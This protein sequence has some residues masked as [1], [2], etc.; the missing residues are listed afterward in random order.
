MSHRTLYLIVG[1]VVA[2]LLVVLF[3]MFDYGIVNADQE[4][5]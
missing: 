3:V 5:A 1:A 4:K 2:V